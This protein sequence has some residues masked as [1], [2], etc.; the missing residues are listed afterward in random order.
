MVPI[1]ILEK[2]INVHPMSEIFNTIQSAYQ[3]LSTK[4]TEYVVIKTFM[5]VEQ[6]NFKC[7]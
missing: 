6:S 2:R 5:D 4:T 7:G 3:K 1:R